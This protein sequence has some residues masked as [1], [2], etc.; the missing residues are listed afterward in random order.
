[1]EKSARHAETAIALAESVGFFRRKDESLAVRGQLELSAGRLSRSSP[2]LDM[3]SVSSKRR[4]DVHMQCWASLLLAQ[5]SIL[6]GDIVEASAAIE[7]AAQFLDRVGR[8]EKIWKTGL[9]AYTAFRNRDFASAADAADHA[10][11]LI[12]MGPPAHVYCFDAYARV[13]EVRVALWAA[14][15]PVRSVERLERDARDACRVVLRSSRIFPLA[16]PAAMLHEGSRRWT[17]RDRRRA[18]QLWA[19]GLAAAQR[20]SLPY[21]EARL[22]LALANASPQG[23]ERSARR[24]AAMKT[25][26]DWSIFDGRDF[27]LAE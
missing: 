20:M 10:A 23:G 25:L 13:A 26:T 7:T 21:Y 19:R 6:A 17:A 5:R 22:E 2:W 18:T 3:L 14:R 1:M 27:Q 8:P 24:L 9:E 11:S 12:A 16:L 15:C 4:G